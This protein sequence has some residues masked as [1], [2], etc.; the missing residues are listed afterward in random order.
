MR[1]CAF[2]LNGMLTSPHL[3]VLPLGLYSILLGMDWLF[4]HEIKVECYDREI[5]FLDDVR[6]KKIL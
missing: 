2:D 5:E 6:E 1:S 4:I 3:N